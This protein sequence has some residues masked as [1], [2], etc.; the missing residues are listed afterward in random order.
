MPEISD[1]AFEFLLARAGL[2]LTEEQK[3]SLAA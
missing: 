3:L 2:F 1:V